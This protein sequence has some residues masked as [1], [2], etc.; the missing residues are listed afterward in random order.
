MSGAQPQLLPEQVFSGTHLQAWLYR[1]GGANLAVTF[2]QMRTDAQ[3]FPP[4]APVKR[5]LRLGHDHLFISSASNDW[6][7]NPDLEPL[8]AC[9]G[10]VVVPYRRVVA[11]GFS[12]GGY[13]TLLFSRALRLNRAV[14]V[15]AQVTPFSAQ[16]PFDPRYRRFEAL[17]DARLGVCAQD[18][19]PGL[20]GFVAF[21]PWLGGGRD[22]AHARLIGAMAP[23]MAMVPIP[24]G[25]HPATK[26]IREAELFGAFQ[27]ILLNP[28]LGWRDAVALRR[29]ARS[30]SA[31]WHQHAAQALARRSARKADGQQV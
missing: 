31:I 22:R 1:A 24:F 15:S 13:A 7:L 19:Q 26:T 8:W 4:P 29:R 11:I 25:G 10:R 9:L 16:A 20:E 17:C 5:F 21:D 30:C 2:F 12:M 14:L 18:V 27:D 23:K 3:G 6:Y 28:E